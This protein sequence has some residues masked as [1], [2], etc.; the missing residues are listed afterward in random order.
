MCSER[1][2]SFV[3]ESSL[4]DSFKLQVDE[5]S[6]AKYCNCNGK[7]MLH[8]PPPAF[9]WQPTYAYGNC[10]HNAI[11]ALVG[12][13]GMAVPP[14]ISQT[15]ASAQ[16]IVSHLAKVIGVVVPISYSDVISAYSGGK[17][18][19]YENALAD[20]IGSS[21]VPEPGLKMFVKVET[22][23]YNPHKPNPAARPI[24]YHNYSFALEMA[25]FIKPFEHALYGLSDDEI[26][27]VGR[28]FFKNLNTFQRA[29]ELRA[30]WESFKNPVAYGWDAHR[31]DAHKSLPV[32][33]ELE[34]KVYNLVF[35]SNRFKK[36]LTK[37]YKTKGKFKMGKNK[38]LSYEVDATQ[39]SG[40]MNTAA[41]N[42]IVMA[43]ILALIYERIGVTWTLA[44]DGDDSVIITEGPTSEEL[45]IQIASEL[46]FV[47]KLEGKWN[48]FEQIKFCQCQPIC[49]DG[50][51]RMVR[52]PQRSII[53]SLSN[54]KYRD[55]RGL[56]K[57]L[58]TVAQG[59]LSLNAGVPILQAFFHRLFTL[60]TEKM[61][62]RS[63]SRNGGWDAEIIADYRY[64]RELTRD[65]KGVGTQ[66][67]TNST[68]L[69][70]S[71]AFGV[72]P[73]DQMLLEAQLEKW[74][75]PAFNVIELEGLQVNGWTWP[76]YLPDCAGP[77]AIL[78]SSPIQRA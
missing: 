64:S 24:Q 18:R 56:P 37:L 71:K 65:W 8:I 50:E 33:K 20:L 34:H 42:C 76:V 29:K 69:S 43:I 21:K 16:H 41:G 44:D 46:G 4:K 25:R 54:P 3:A 22:N 61:S 36:M 73:N 53:K 57:K 74:D 35:K 30:K 1:G 10:A 32:M 72:S 62:N 28:T 52:D 13:V 67:I 58:R 31:Y 11:S 2:I 7:R 49:V 78:G 47:L 55:V 75:L 77:Y 66:P 68:R 70:F 12:R 60:A 19:R 17:K 9:V 40:G 59:E 51:W 45:P 38:V 63:L 5:I 23:I 27:G 14:T 39:V 48:E 6:L 15:L 26:F